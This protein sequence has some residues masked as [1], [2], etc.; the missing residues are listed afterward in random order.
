MSSTG[1]KPR[2]VKTPPLLLGATLLFW[3]WQ[4][5][6][7]I[8]GIIMAAI[9]ESARLVRVRWDLPENDFKR[10]AYF[11]ELLG[12]AVALY[13]FSQ[14]EGPSGIG[15]MLRGPSALHNA[16]VTAA[17]TATMFFRWLPLIF[18]L[19]VAAQMY[20]VTETIPLTSI[21]P[22]LRRYRQ[23]EAKAG[24]PVPPMRHVNLTYPYF[25]ICIFSAGVHINEGTDSF[26]WGQTMLL[27]WALWPFRSQ[28]YKLLIWTFVFLVV[29]G[30]GF[31]TQFGI[32]ILQQR[33]QNYN[34]RWLSYFF[35]P[36]TDP[37][38]SITAIG[39]L[40]QLK[41]SGRIVIRLRPAAGQ[42]APSY[43]REASYRTYD[44]RR[45]RWFA[46]SSPQAFEN[47]PVYPE[48]NQTTFILLPGKTNTA[49]VN[50]ASYLHGSRNGNSS[51]LLPLPPGCSRLDNLNAY[52]LQKNPEG[53][54]LVAEGPG[55][56]IF[57]A[58]YGPGATIDAP[59]QAITNNLDYA[60]PTNEMPA[61]DQVIAENHLRGDTERQTLENVASFFA[62]NFTYST[63]Q[64][65]DKLA[66]TN[67]T[68]MGRFLS[69]SRSG[70][71]EYFATATVLLLRELRIPARYAVGYA[72]HE[73]SGS[74][75]V[76][77]QRDAHAW[78]LVWDGSAKAWKDFDTTPGSW[79]DVEGQ[80]AS[81]WEKLSDL[82][83]WLGF[84]IAKLRWGQ[85]HLREYILWALI[86]V[87]ILLLYQIIF[88]HGRK[89]RRTQSAGKRE[90]FSWP[91]L[92]SEFYRLEQKLSQQGVPRRPGEPL[93][94]WLE[95][96]LSDP[97]LTA[98]RAPLHDLLQLHYRYRFD[99]QGLSPSDRE[100]LTARAKTCLQALSNKPGD[101]NSVV[102]PAN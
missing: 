17:Q 84:Q 7:L 96:A 73:P 53:A 33:M 74:G 80:R 64:G 36:R 83:S 19:A 59:P 1:T 94:D 63:W 6:L 4:S 71:C 91:G 38:Q 52:I 88:R 77:R 8:V 68:P 100:R 47:G 29:V 41:L 92:D 12:L 15:G 32:R 31:E 34:M 90:V 40:G 42:M 43:L 48:T 49:S 45:Q 97:A 24:R 10:I 28:R 102:T 37:L 3:G 54:V 87:L 44:P 93:S 89:R 51:G 25:I 66:T 2:I 57:D 11:C 98:L 5:N 78:C 35:R 55:L 99:P 22:F 13:A 75:Y 79:V 67:Q 14:N 30:F 81:F 9:M 82:K 72:V 58:A 27:A 61:L 46:G 23:R 16:S 85:S 50:I 70:H 76:V 18:F 101:G 86:P 62:K 21:S 60:V 95:R 65:A 56:V 20:S 39:E 69:T 26:F